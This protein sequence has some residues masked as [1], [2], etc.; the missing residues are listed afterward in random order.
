MRTRINRGKLVF[1]DIAEA[2][3]LAFRLE[4]RDRFFELAG[5]VALMADPR[6]D[7]ALRAGLER[8]LEDSS[9][10]SGA[11]ARGVLRARDYPWSRCVDA[12]VDAYSFVSRG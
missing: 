7:D 5:D 8:V 12:T 10:R 3:R 9:W 2:T 1:A 4:R 6:D 11:S